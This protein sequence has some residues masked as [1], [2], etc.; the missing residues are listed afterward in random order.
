MRITPKEQIKTKDQVP[1]VITDTAQSFEECALDIVSP[2]T[3]ST[4][5]N[6]YIFIF[7]DNHTKFSKIIR[8][9]IKK[10]PITAQ[11]FD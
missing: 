1:L 4:N 9:N 11:Q 10:L 5:S 2:L 3:L 6:K 7:Q 8:Y